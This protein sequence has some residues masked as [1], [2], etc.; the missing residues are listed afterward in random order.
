MGFESILG[1][2][3]DRAEAFVRTNAHFKDRTEQIFTGLEGR[4]G[5]IAL[6]DVRRAVDILFDLLANQLDQLGIAVSRPSPDELQQLLQAAH[7]NQISGLDEQ[8]FRVRDF[9]V[10]EVQ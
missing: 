4:D 7:A 9:R 3:E 1:A 5:K 8:Q 6:V 10:G 2:V